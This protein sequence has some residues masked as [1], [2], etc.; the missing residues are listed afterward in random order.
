MGS[1]FAEE[2]LNNFFEFAFCFS[3]L[4]VVSG[5]QLEINKSWLPGGCLVNGGLSLRTNSL[6]RKKQEG[7]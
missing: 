4:S 6:R 1:D 2:F 7:A 3:A 5:I